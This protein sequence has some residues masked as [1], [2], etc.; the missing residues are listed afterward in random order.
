V[1]GIGNAVG[2]QGFKSLPKPLALIA[3]EL[4]SGPSGIHS[5][6]GDV[7]IAVVAVGVAVASE[8]PDEVVIVVGGAVLEGG[9]LLF[10][11]DC[12]IKYV[13]NTN[14]IKQT[15]LTGVADDLGRRDDEA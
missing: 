9:L 4:L 14:P 13:R 10:S 15:I 2:R 5:S 6:T 11:I 1:F 3:R 7:A 8:V 12:T